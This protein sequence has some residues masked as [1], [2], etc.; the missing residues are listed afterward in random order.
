MDGSSNGKQKK[1]D[2]NKFTGM[3]FPSLKVIVKYKIVVNFSAVY[4]DIKR[5]KSH[6]T[7]FTK[8]KLVFYVPFNSQ[9]HIGTGPR[10]CQLW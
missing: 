8:S 6:D 5:H 7:F 1:T 2:L 4:M 3:K 9:G 10:L